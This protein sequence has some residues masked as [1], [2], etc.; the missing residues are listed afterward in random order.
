MV[1]YVDDREGT[2]I[3]SPDVPRPYLLHGPDVLEDL[4]DHVRPV[5]AAQTR[6]T[7]HL[8]PG[9]QHY[10]VILSPEDVL[11]FQF[12]YNGNMYQE[13]VVYMGWRQ[14]NRLRVLDFNRLNHVDVETRN[15][16]GLAATQGEKYGTFRNFNELG[17][18]LMRTADWNISDAVADGS[19]FGIHDFYVFHEGIF[20]GDYDYFRQSECRRRGLTKRTDSTRS[21]TTKRAGG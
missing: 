19:R 18:A 5:L 2:Y 12:E 9:S 6:T 1:Y 16:V 13:H 14:Q 4:R 21:G 10:Q 3:V 17:Q 11:V 20:M 7:S 8:T 15:S